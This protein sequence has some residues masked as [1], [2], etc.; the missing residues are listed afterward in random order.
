[1]SG[2]TQRERQDERPCIYDQWFECDGADEGSILTADENETCAESDLQD[3]D[4]G[5][6]VHGGECLRDER[7]ESQRLFDCSSPGGSS[8][9]LTY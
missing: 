5:C 9:S 8:G 2:T 3:V 4:E 6:K 1:V 7:C